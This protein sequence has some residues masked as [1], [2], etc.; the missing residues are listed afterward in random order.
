MPS[1]WVVLMLVYTSLHM[2]FLILIF[3]NAE[4][5]NNNN[6]RINQN[7]GDGLIK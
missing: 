7:S 3:D 5:V 1:A 6:K 2:Y 4:L